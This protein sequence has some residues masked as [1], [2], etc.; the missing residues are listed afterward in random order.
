MAVVLTASL[1]VF[2]YGFM[3]LFFGRDVIEEPDAGPLVG[4]LMALTACAV[5][6][7]FVLT[8]RPAAPGRR[9]VAAALTAAIAVPLAGALAYA[10]VRGELAASAVFFGRN[11]LSP[12]VLAADVIVAL[13]VAGAAAAR[14]YR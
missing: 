13:V 12:F 6:L 1:I 10:A 5:V 7:R 3:S 11:I 9:S 2:V 8:E 14:L 4:P